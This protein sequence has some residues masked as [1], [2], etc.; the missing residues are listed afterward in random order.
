MPLTSKGRGH[1]TGLAGR[2]CKARG[3]VEAPVIDEPEVVLV[4]AR[5]AL[6]LGRR[7]AEWALE[8]HTAGGV[9]DPSAQ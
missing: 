5:R 2:A 9:V 4:A 1:S 8:L 7:V 6:L 3:A